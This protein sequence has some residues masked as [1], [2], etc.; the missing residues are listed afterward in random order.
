M[1]EEI[2]DV[3]NKL[4]SSRRYFNSATKEYNNAVETF[5]SNLVAGSFNF[6]KEEMFE[7]DDNQ[8]ENM[9]TPPKMNFDS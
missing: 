9:E 5:P 3:E 1:Q 8:R 6:S 4:A 2:S 7:I